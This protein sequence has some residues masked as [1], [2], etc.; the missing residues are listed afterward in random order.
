M[1]QAGYAIKGH[2]D[3]SWS[4]CSNCQG[5]GQISQ[6]LAIGGAQ[7]V[8]GDTCIVCNGVGRVPDLAWPPCECQ[9]EETCVLCHGLGLMSPWVQARIASGKLLVPCATCKG[10]G[11]VP[12]QSGKGRRPLEAP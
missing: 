8:R 11:A 2:Q 7:G 4:L 10:S 5:F 1:P 9:G 12:Y 3:V 6:E